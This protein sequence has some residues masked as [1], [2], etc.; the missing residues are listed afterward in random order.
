MYSN[1]EYGFPLIFSPDSAVPSPLPEGVN[2]DLLVRRHAELK[3]INEMKDSLHN[4]M[5]KIS[6][7]ELEITR[8]DLSNFSK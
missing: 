2:F 6:K 1:K 8:N 5:R 3:Q 4:Y 7:T